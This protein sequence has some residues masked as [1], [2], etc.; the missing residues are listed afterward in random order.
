MTFFLECISR[1]DP[2]P[3]SVCEIGGGYG[4]PCRLWLTNALHRPQRYAILDLPE[5][6]FFSEVFLRHEFGDCGV[7]YVTSPDPLDPGLIDRVNVVL[8]PVAFHRTLYNTPF[9]LVYNTLSMQ[10]M[11]D[12]FVAFYGRWLDEQ[13]VKRFYSFNYAAEPSDA[14]PESA[15]WGAPR[16]SRRW[17][18]LWVADYAAASSPAR[19]IL[20]ER[21]A[22][23]N[24]I[25]ARGQ[26][27]FDQEIEKPYNAVNFIK[28]M[29]SARMMSDAR[30]TCA[31]IRKVIGENGPMSR[32]VM[33]MLEWIPDQCFADQLSQSDKQV[34]ESAGR[35][36]E[37]RMPARGKVSP[38]LQAI[39]EGLL[40]DA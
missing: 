37:E 11:S 4:G 34:L 27:L 2:R 13:P 32:E 15:N 6:L 12:E 23:E 25:L 19:H 22:N 16:L 30:A 3:Q 9:D 7:H 8:C 29:M 17:Y 18:P 10:E 36:L 40:P 1:I 14:H 35:R 21:L 33:L 39:R 26:M 24:E 28:L 20:A 38:H 5:S 31:V